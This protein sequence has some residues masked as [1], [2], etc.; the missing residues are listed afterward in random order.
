M[1][2]KK[3]KEEK[4]RDK[5][6]REQSKKRVRDEIEHGMLPKALV[7]PNDIWLLPPPTIQ[8]ND[9]NRFS[10]YV[11]QCNEILEAMLQSYQPGEAITNEIMKFIERLR[12]RR[13]EGRNNITHSKF[14]ARG[15]ISESSLVFILECKALIIESRRK[16]SFLFENIPSKQVPN[17]FVFDHDI[18]KILNSKGFIM[19]NRRTYSDNPNHTYD[20]NMTECYQNLLILRVYWR[21]WT[22]SIPDCEKL[23]NY[24]QFHYAK[25][26]C[27]TTR[28]SNFLNGKP[29]KEVEYDGKISSS[30]DM[31]TDKRKCL[32]SVTFTYIDE[33]ASIFLAF[34]SSLIFRKQIY[35]NKRFGEVKLVEW[36]SMLMHEKDRYLF[37]EEIQNCFYDWFDLISE[38][39]ADATFC[40]EVVNGCMSLDARPGEKQIFLIK[41]NDVPVRDMKRTLLKTRTQVQVEY[42]NTETLT[43]SLSIDLRFIRKTGRKTLY[44]SAIL[45]LFQSYVRSNCNNFDWLENC[46]YL[47]D[48]F[49]DNSIKLFEKT[50]PIIVQLYSSFYVLFKKNMILCHTI[51]RCIYLWLYII[52]NLKWKFRTVLSEFNLF[53]LEQVWTAWN[54]TQVEE[55]NK[56]NNNNNNNN[57]ILNND[58]ENPENNYEQERIRLEN[59]LTT[60]DGQIA[61]VSFDDISRIYD[62]S[63]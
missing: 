46:V 3:Q 57:Q 14:V 47:E 11:N 18:G 1:S 35:V 10:W 38:K 55:H 31:E 17:A 22:F 37:C 59:S 43:R 60:Q 42:L 61:K 9:F 25:V 20:F 8:E 50:M 32:K 29:G 21:E 4:E 34:F 54:M 5:T 13:Q 16:N 26:L 7:T 44:I 33:I 6:I 27:R 41:N 15:K 49:I 19:P 52:K 28:D 51:D 24:F 63:K 36:S 39:I 53:Q 12:F 58:N 2:T 23:L 30:S 40:G 48:E 45:L 56:R 62:F